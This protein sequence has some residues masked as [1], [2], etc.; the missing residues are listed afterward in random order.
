MISNILFYGVINC[1]HKVNIIATL[2]SFYSYSG[3]SLTSLVEIYNSLLLYKLFYTLDYSTRS[4]VKDS[5]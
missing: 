3:N 2:I 4:Y 1:L 5:N